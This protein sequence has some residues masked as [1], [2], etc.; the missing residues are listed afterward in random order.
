MPN[1]QFSVIIAVYNGVKTIEKAIDSVLSQTFV[2]FEL[3]VV[4][5]GSTDGTANVVKKYGNKV[6]YFYQPNA[7]VSVARNKG[8]EVAKGDW[9]AFLDADDWYYPDRLKLHAEWIAREPDLDFLTGDFDYIRPDGSHIR[10]SI[11]STEAGAMLLTKQRT[12]DEVV[13]E[14]E[15]IGKFIEQHFGD[16]HTLSLPRKTFLRLGGYPKGIAVCED[17]NFLIRLCAASNKVGVICQPMAA[18]VIHDDSAT[19]SN[20]I[21]AQKQTLEALIPLRDQLKR[22]SKVIKDGL[23]GAIRHARIDFAYALLKAGHHLKAIQ[24]VLPM[25]YQNPGWTSLRDLASIIRG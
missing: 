19:R 24:V 16:T 11:E 23:E 8:A 17:V 20:P 14:G 15:M 1:P 18:Y 10:R 12:N 3:I 13:M 5:D 25:L 7:G 9:L 2:P 6:R 21:R 4:D 22:A